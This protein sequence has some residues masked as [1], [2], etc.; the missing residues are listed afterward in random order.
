ML[1]DRTGLESRKRLRLG[2]KQLRGLVLADL[3]V[4]L[5]VLLHRLVQLDTHLRDFG[6]ELTLG[7]LERFLQLGLLL[8]DRVVVREEDVA[9]RLVD[10]L[11]LLHLRVVDNLLLRADGLKIEI[12]VV[13]DL[14]IE[15]F[16]LV[17]LCHTVL[18]FRSDFEILVRML[19]D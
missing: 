18:D 7:L 3:L 10:L 9:E 19:D 6:L 1:L 11:E 8:D 4:E 16:R 15:A 5:L 2:F 17:Y 14:A 12:K 13:V